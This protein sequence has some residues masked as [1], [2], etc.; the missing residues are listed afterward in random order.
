MKGVEFDP[1]KMRCTNM[2]QITIDDLKIRQPV[3]AIWRSCGTEKDTFKLVVSKVSS[4]TI[5]KNGI[6][7]K[8]SPQIFRTPL[9]I[10]EFYDFRELNASGLVMVDTPLLL[11]SE[12]I[13]HYQKVV[14]HWNKHGVKSCLEKD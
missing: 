13:E 2:K 6:K 11:S 10:E 1:V 12:T 4:I 14:E 5:N 9:D 3:G 7:V 8:T